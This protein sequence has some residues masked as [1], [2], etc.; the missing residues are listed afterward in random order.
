M[1]P[2]S[3]TPE[4]RLSG[5]RSQ[6]P[7]RGPKQKKPPALQSDCERVWQLRSP[8][9]PCIGADRIGCLRVLTRTR[10]CRC[11]TM[12][13]RHW[14]AKAICGMQMWSSAGLDGGPFKGTLPFYLL[15]KGLRNLGVQL[16][17]QAGFGCPLPIRNP[18]LPFDK[19]RVMKRRTAMCRMKLF[20]I[21]DSF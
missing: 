3:G 19:P 15:S 18:F 17:F 11:R 4:T 12:R 8:A 20:F 13:S 5:C 10:P 21:F 2:R 14:A 1:R 7:C 9:F 16:S 6:P